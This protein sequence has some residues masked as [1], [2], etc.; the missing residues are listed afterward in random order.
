MNDLKY[1]VN[2][3]TCGHCV[4]SVKKEVNTVTGVVN[5]EVDLASKSVVV[6]GTDVK[7]EDVRQAILEAGYEI[8]N[9]EV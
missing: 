5:V 8:S 2:G 1:T 6:S 9:S 7:D 4:E 3:M